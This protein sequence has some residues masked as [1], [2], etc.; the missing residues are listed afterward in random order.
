MP[1][2]ESLNLRLTTIYGI[3]SLVCEKADSPGVVDPRRAILVH[4]GSVVEHC[5]QVHND[6]TE[7]AQSDL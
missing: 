7:S 6:K 1:N 4:T 5:Q 2:R 3:K